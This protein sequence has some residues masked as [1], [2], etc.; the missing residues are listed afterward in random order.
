MEK[1]REI[2]GEI[3]TARDPPALGNDQFRP[4]FLAEPPHVLDRLTERFRVGS[5]PV[6]HSSEIRYRHNHR[7]RRYIPVEEGG[8][9]RFGI[10]V[11]GE[12]G[13]RHPDRKRSSGGDLKGEDGDEDEEEEKRG[14]GRVDERGETR[15]LTVHSE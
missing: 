6:S 8:A 2:S 3:K 12:S 10:G 15:F 7:L 9:G 11:R 13:G 5:P 1:K 4:A 14:A